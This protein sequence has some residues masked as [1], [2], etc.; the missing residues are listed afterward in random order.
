MFKKIIFHYFALFISIPFSFADDLGYPK[1]DEGIGGVALS[2]ASLSGDVDS[3]LGEVSNTTSNLEALDS[4]LDELESLI[5]ENSSALEDVS[6]TT[7][8]SVASSTSGDP[9]DDYNWISLTTNSN[10]VKDYNYDYS[11]VKSG[12]FYYGEASSLLVPDSAKLL[13][14]NGQIVHPD[15]TG[16]VYSTP[17]SINNLF[18]SVFK[19]TLSNRNITLSFIST[20]KISDELGWIWNTS[21]YGLDFTVYYLEG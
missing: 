10:G 12:N 9:W 19:V 16:V 13:L 17:I 8:S 15:S 21:A 3:L 11:L 20:D 5:L 14:I 6:S 2:S 1:I 7:I 18:S 4:K